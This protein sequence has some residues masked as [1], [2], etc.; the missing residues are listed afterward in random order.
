LDRFGNV[1]CGDGVVA[2]EVRDRTGDASDT[3]ER[4]R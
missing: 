1:M 4:A 3:V 2:G